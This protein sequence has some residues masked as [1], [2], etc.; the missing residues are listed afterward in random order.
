ME[1]YY[2]RFV[3]VLTHESFRGKIQINV[4]QMLTFC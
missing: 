4:E 3:L 1:Q 2:F